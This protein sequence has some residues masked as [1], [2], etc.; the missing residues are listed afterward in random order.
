MNIAVIRN[1]VVEKEIMYALKQ[2][3]HNTKYISLL[4]P[5]NAF[6]N[7]ELI[8]STPWSHYPISKVNELR[9]KGVKIAYWSRA[10]PS[11]EK[12]LPK[13]IDT[14]DYVFTPYK[15]KY[16][17][18]P[19][20]ASSNPEWELRHN[21]KWDVCSIVMHNEGHKGINKLKETYKNLK[22]KYIIV[23]PAWDRYPEFNSIYMKDYNQRY[24]YYWD[25][26]ISINI[27]KSVDALPLR[28]FETCRCRCFPIFYESELL[29]E[30]YPTELLV[31]FND[32]T[33]VSKIYEKIDYYLDESNNK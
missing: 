22:R 33:K 17:Y 28:Y 31:T 30:I 1:Y 29:N 2:L 18:L 13:F 5:I 19:L 24:R 25:S 11:I 21:Y 9:K 16:N 3:G 26:K 20:C 23:G 6:K 27:L 10:T 7:I 12:E 8:I 14:A 15:S 32:N 4:S